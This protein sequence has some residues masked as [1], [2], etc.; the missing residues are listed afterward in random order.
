MNE[1]LQ[2]IFSGVVA[3]STI[4]YAFLT[5]KLVSETRKTRQFQQTPDI[6]IRL[7]VSEA[8]AGFLYIIFENNGLGVAKDVKFDIIDDFQYYDHEHYK[9]S[10]KGIVKNGLP[11]FYSHQIF[12]Y[13]LTDTSQNQEQKETDY[14]DV[15]ALY[16]DTLGRSYDK[17]F[18][19]QIADI[20]GETR[21]SPPET[22]LGRVAFYLKEIRNI[23]C[24]LQH[25]SEDDSPSS[26]P[27]A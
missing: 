2:I 8:D 27:E 5:W 18:R 1:C 12:R 3:G 13:Y 22:Y 14:I 16:T 25:R 24:K 23:M 6:N 7:E 11:Y 9:L 26:K 15:K 20:A 19:L 10:S 17:L 21:M 4:V